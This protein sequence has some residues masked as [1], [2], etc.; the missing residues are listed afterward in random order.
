MADRCDAGH[1][2]SEACALLAGEKA[3]RRRLCSVLQA[4]IQEDQKNYYNNLVDE[5]EEGLRNNQPAES[6]LPST[7]P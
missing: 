5:A 4:H 1:R 7:V 3:E 6:C 2:R